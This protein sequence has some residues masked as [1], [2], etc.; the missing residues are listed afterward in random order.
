[1]SLSPQEQADIAEQVQGALQRTGLSPATTC[2]LLALFVTAAWLAAR[3]R[4]RRDPQHHSTNSAYVFA[5]ASSCLLAAITTSMIFR[6]LV[7]ARIACL[8]IHG[9]HTCGDNIMD[10]YGIVSQFQNIVSAHYSLGRY[11]L[12]LAFVL[13]FSFIGWYGV[14]AAGRA[15]RD[16][17]RGP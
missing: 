12:M 4:W 15:L 6:A 13:A 16:R 17:W 11:T 3:A 5:F 10:A 9:E 7:T 2:V 1:M 8:E 14:F